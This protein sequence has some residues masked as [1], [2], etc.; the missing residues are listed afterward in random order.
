MS[1]KKNYE[2]WKERIENVTKD[3]LK[4]PDMPIDVITADAETLKVEAQKDKDE[5]TTVGL[6]WSLVET[7]DSLSGAVRYTQTE[8]MS[9][10]KAQQEAQKQWKEQLPTGVNLRGELLHHFTFAYRDEPEILLKIKRIREG[11]GYDDMI[12]DLFELGRLGEKYPAPL[13]KINFN[14]EM[15]SQAKTLSQQLAKLRA[16]SNGSK[17]DENVNKLLRD[18]AYTLLSNHLKEIRDY[19]QYV[20]WRTPER[21]AKYVNNYR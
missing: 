12:Q 11:S 4:E 1:F 9:D 10:F 19:G 16:L 18:K 2:N 8:W 3:E 6:D 13:N 20:F 7:L 17:D 21:K 15:N 14:I 5:L